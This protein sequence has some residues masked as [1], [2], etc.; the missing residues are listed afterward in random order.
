MRSGMCH[1]AINIPPGLA[2][3]Q[4]ASA[5][6]ATLSLVCYEG[7]PDTRAL[8]E[9]VCFADGERHELCLAGAADTR[10]FEILREERGR[11]DLECERRRIAA[12]ERLMFSGSRHT[13]I[14]DAPLG[15]LV[16]LRLARGAASPV[17]AREY[18]IADGTLIH[19]ASG[20]RGESRDEMAAAVLGA[21]RRGDAV[22]VLAAI[23]G[24]EAGGSEHL[25][26]QA[27]CQA[28][29]LNTAAG[30]ALLTDRALDPTDPLAEPAGALRATLIERHPELSS[31]SPR[32]RAL[33]DCPDAHRHDVAA[34]LDMLG[35]GG[36]DPQDEASV[37]HAALALRRLGNDRTF[38]GDLLIAQLKDRHR[39][40]GES[41]AYGAQ[42]VVL[43][44]PRGGC[45]LRANIWPSE[46]DACF[47]SSGAKTFVYGL[48]HDHNFSFLTVGYLGP[49]Y[50]SDYYEYDYEAAAGYAGETPGLRF[51]R[52]QRAGRGQ[53]DALPRTPRHPFAASGEKPL[54]QP[55]HHAHPPRGGVVRP[56]RLRPRQRRDHPRA[57]SDLERDL[58][59]LRGGAGRARSARSWQNISAGTISATGC[60]WQASRPGRCF[61]MGRQRTSCGAR[62]SFP[63]A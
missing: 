23:A 14:V 49:G 62:R 20:D 33:I 30:F 2:V 46:R 24:E 42:S 37:A 7:Q 5:G 4:L 48:P 29:A 19:C 16:I 56:I 28:L 52:A 44:A 61:S 38:L 63:G 32:C 35:D 3:L 45:F 9:T 6:R 41:S 31:W 25:R 53:A 58:P 60:G 18:R 15:R 59:A 12:G 43:S 55:Q 26:W 1:F 17:P 22:P 8:A 51:R 34:C 11:A 54:G 21:M 50:A 57:E 13:R 47:R 40:I 27:L 39:D 10:L 36:F